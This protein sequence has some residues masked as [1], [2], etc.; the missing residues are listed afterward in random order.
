MAL[1]TN[2]RSFIGRGKWFI[3][4]KSAGVQSGALLRVGNV[5]AASFAITE[6][7]KEVKDY[8]SLGGGI[9]DSIS[10]I[11]KVE[12]TMTIYDYSPE[13]LALSIRGTKTAVTAGTVAAEAHN[14]V[15]AGSFVPFDYIPDPSVAPV[16]TK[17]PSTV[18]VAGTDYSVYPTG[19][20][21][22]AG[23]AVVNG[24]DL[25]IGYTKNKSN[26]IQ[27]LVSSASEY[28]LFFE[29]LNEMDG[30]NPLPLRVHRIKFSPTAGLGLLSDDPST[31]EL[32]FDVLSDSTITA[33]GISQFFSLGMVVN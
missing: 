17:L 25:T 10:R 27:A 15:F 16:V 23:G 22:I 5:S 2:T 3:A 21:L 32:K 9:K 6:E 29:G 14:D 8:E 11:S 7:K 19:I 28:L 13:N 12:G 20:Q 4:P 1:T 18:L 31:L 30:G 26:V 24:D 33:P